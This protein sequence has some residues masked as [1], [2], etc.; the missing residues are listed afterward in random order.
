MTVLRFF[1]SI[2]LPVEFDEK[3]LCDDYKGKPLQPIQRD[4]KSFLTK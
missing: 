3:P 4:F 1:E 2:K